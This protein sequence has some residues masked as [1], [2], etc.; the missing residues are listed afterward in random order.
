[1]REDEERQ[2]VTIGAPAASAGAVPVG[3]DPP[4]PPDE[5]EDEASEGEDGG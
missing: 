3:E 1:M 4:G 2:D 5:E